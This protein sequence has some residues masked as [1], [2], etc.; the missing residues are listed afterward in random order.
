MKASAPQQMPPAQ[1]ARA[2]KILRSLRNARKQAI[3]T[4]RQHGTPVIYL[5]KGRVVREWP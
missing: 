1:K 4:A 3:E 5:E 2:Q